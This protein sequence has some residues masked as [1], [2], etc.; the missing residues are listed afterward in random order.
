MPTGDAYSSG[1]L[2]PSLG[3]V[4]L[5][6]TYPFSELVVIFKGCAPRISIGTFSILLQYNF[7]LQRPR[8][9]DRRRLLLRT[10]VLYPFGPAFV[11]P[12]KLFSHA[13]VMLSGF[14]L[15]TSLDASVLLSKDCF[16]FKLQISNFCS[17]HS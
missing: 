4:L 9:A 5:V 1:H 6:E 14:E 10:L 13:L 3:Y 16:V 11:L 2:V 17:I 12:L 8:L 15:Q 7:I